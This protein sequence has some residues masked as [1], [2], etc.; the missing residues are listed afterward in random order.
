MDFAPEAIAK[1]VYKDAA[2]LAASMDREL[3]QD[4]EDPY[5]LEALRTFRDKYIDVDKKNC[6]GQLAD[7]IESLLGK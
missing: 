6:T 4:A 7:F 3:A 2:E 1:Y 5:D